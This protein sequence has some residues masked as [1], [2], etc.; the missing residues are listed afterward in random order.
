MLGVLLLQLLNS[1]RSALGKY[2]L[3]YLRL[4]QDEATH[5]AQPVALPH[6]S[7]PTVTKMSYIEDLNIS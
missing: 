5:V 7:A 4:C 3:A 6:T 1:E 2:P